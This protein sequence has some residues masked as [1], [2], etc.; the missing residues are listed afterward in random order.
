MSGAR[1]HFTTIAAAAAF[2]LAACS[3]A[4]GDGESAATPADAAAGSAAPDRYDAEAFFTTTSYSL[5]GGYAWSPDDSKLLVS[6]DETGI[7]NAYALAAGDGAAEPLTT[8]TT[9]STFAVSWFPNDARML[10]SADQ[11]GN[12]LDHLYVREVDGTTRDL[13]PGEKVKA[14]FDGWSA[15]GKSFYVQ[16]RSDERRV[17]EECVSTCRFRGSRYNK[18]NKKRS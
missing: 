16:T 1:L 17:G 14:G 12:E 9:D 10:Y 5:P 4:G 8:S 7:F 13:T 3:P 11:G 15:D 2:F 6:S 18:K